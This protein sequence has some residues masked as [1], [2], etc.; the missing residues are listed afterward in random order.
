MLPKQ[1]KYG[2]KVESAYAKAYRTNI[3]PQNGTGPYNFG[4]TII[5][6]IPTRANTVLV[7]S[8]SYLKFTL[9]PIQFAAASNLRLDK[10]GVHGIIQKITIFHGSNQL[11]ITDEYGMFAKMIFDLESPT[12]ANFNKNNVMVGTRNDL[13]VVPTN[14]P[15]GNPY[16]VL[17][18]TGGESVGTNIAAGGFTTATTYCIN[19]ISLIG[20]LCPNYYLPLFA[21]TSSPL[22]VEIML[23][24]ADIQAFNVITIATVP[25]PNGLISN[26]EYIGEFIDLGDEAMKIIEAS[27]EGKPLQ[28]VFSSFRNFQY[29]YAI[30]TASYTQVNM[31]I[32]AKFSSL[33]SIFVCQRDAGT[34]LVAHYPFSSVNYGLYNYQFRLG[35]HVVPSKPV[36]DIISMYSE[37]V[38]SIGSMSDLH[39]NPSIRK[40]S[41]LISAS[42]ANTVLLETH[43]ASNIISGSF[44][45]GMNLENYVSAPKDT[46]FSGYNS[47]TDD[48]FF[49]ANYNTNQNN[50]GGTGFG[51]NPVNYTA[52]ALPTVTLRYDAYAMFDCVLV[53]ENGTCFVRF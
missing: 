16:P 20:T 51:S 21:M 36:D 14:A 50:I 8:E 1:L 24:S 43:N 42:T 34:G 45:V 53:C 46:M 19:L 35:S 7:P 11:E 37:L 3:A 38:K 12:D 10:C 26:V 30:Q 52:A 2:S 25:Y 17:Q 15:D 31:P 22:R 9:Q 49:I 40:S 23:K 4:D 47:N 48:I 13:V 28:F 27:L 6:N 29:S 39:F 18:I 44:Y 32:A 41:Y 5:F 33:K